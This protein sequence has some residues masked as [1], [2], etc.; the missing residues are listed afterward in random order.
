M[1]NIANSL[2]QAVIE[3]LDKTQIKSITI[4]DDFDVYY[5]DQINKLLYDANKEIVTRLD[6]LDQHNRVSY[7]KRYLHLFDKRLEWHRMM[8]DDRFYYLQDDSGYNALEIDNDTYI[9]IYREIMNK[10]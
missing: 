8:L 1:E 7:L 10:Q 5:C 4:Y 9:E 6:L 3:L 2:P